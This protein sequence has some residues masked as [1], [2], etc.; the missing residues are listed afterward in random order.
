MGKNYIKSHYKKSNVFGK[1]QKINDVVKYSIALAIISLFAFVPQIGFLTV[2]NFG[3]ALILL[4][5]IVIG[6]CWGIWINLFVWTMFGIYALILSYTMIPNVFMNNP[7][8]SVVARICVGII[9]TGWKLL[10]S[11]SKKYYNLQNLM[12]Y[13]SPILNTIFVVLFLQVST[14]LK[15]GIF[16]G[17][18]WGIIAFLSITWPNII[19]EWA[20]LIPI[21]LTVSMRINKYNINL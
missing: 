11:K 14:W 19:I 8:P 1:K 4:P 16:D 10:F 2:N 12:I 9:V 17:S 3:L 7:L 18:N 20:I 13:I 21:G 15:V 5:I 6:A